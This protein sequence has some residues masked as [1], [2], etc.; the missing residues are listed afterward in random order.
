IVG[1]VFCAIHCTA[2]N[3]AFPSSDEKWMWR[4]WAV[5]VTA[6]P[7]LLLVIVGILLGIDSDILEA[8]AQIVTYISINIPVYIV[9]RLFLILLPF[10]TLRALPSGAFLDV[11]WNVYIPLCKLSP[12]LKFTHGGRVL[13]FQL[14][15]LHPWSL[16]MI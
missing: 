10:T 4:S 15:I 16:D 14:S 1:S 12:S 8:G 11:D 9:A 13:H 3:A 5:L 2:W 6:L 7:Q